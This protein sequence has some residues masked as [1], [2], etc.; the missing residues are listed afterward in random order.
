MMTYNH[1]S[2]GISTSRHN[3]THSNICKEVG[4][5]IIQ[6]DMG[7]TLTPEQIDSVAVGPSQITLSLNNDELIAIEMN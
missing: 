3:S 2:K 4:I 7:I 6:S 5:D 1:Q